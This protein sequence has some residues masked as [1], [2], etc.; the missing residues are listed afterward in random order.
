MPLTPID[1]QQKTF[2]T[3]LRG[4]D[5][6]EVDDFLDAVVTA[7]KDYEQRVRDA[8][9]RIGTLE[10]QATDRGDAEG[11]IARALVAA[12]RSADAIVEEAKADAARIVAE[13][14][15]E[16]TQFTQARDEERADAESE[17]ERIR[18]LVADL[19]TRLLGLA[20]VLGGSLDEAEAA[21]GDTSSALDQ[22]WIAPGDDDGLGPRHVSHDEPD[23]PGD[24]D[25]ADSDA[26]GWSDDG[27]DQSDGSDDGLVDEQVARSE[28]TTPDDDDD[29]G[30]HDD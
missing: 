27:S 4:Y 25:E 16:A 29:D 13:A 3:A 15:A 12:Q 21:I 10:N 17:V 22:P 5:L 8:Q 23:V 11:A 26:S 28:W 7:L 20:G 14:R 6:D 19:R 24:L 18:G 2:G 9:E 30:D 1:V